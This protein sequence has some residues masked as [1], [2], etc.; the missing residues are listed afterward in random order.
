MYTTSP[1]DHDVCKAPLGFAALHMSRTTPGHKAG[2]TLWRV[3]TTSHDADAT[4][5]IL[6]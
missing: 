2:A 3:A 5:T 6:A 4:D 1:S